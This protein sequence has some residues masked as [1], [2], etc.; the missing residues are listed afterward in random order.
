VVW[1]TIDE[2]AH[3]PDEYA[4]IENLTKDALVFAKLMSRME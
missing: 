4:K 3:Q 2:L 1:A